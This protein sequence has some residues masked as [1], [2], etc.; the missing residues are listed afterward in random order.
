MDTRDYFKRLC[1]AGL[2]TYS[3]SGKIGSGKFNCGEDQDLGLCWK[4][5]KLGHSC[6]DAGFYFWRHEKLSEGN[7]KLVS[8]LV[9][10]TDKFLLRRETHPKTVPSLWDL[11]P[12]KPPS[13]VSIVLQLKDMLNETELDLALGSLTTSELHEFHQS[14]A[15]VGECKADEWLD[16]DGVVGPGQENK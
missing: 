2:I 13:I 7:I 10:G 4:T 6:K 12:T 5:L 11:P 14:I 16:T 15:M 9:A 8:E 3:D 1:N